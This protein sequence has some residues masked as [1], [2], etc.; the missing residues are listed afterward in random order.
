MIAP[1]LVGLM[2]IVFLLI[3]VW[4]QSADESIPVGDYGKHLLIAFGYYDLI[5]AGHYGAPFREY[6]LYPPLTHLVGA[7]YSLFAGGPT[8]ARMVIAENLVFVPALAFGCYWAGSV[9]FNRLA[10]VLAAVFALGTPMI[11]SLF[12]IFM[13]DGPTAAMVALTVA[14]MLASRRFESLRVSAL[15]GAFAGVGMYT[16]STFVLFIVGLFLTML[17]RGGWRQRRGV[18]TFVG[19]AFVIAGP[20]YIGHFHDLFSQTQGAVSAQQPLW[21]GSHPYPTPTQ[22]LKYTWYGWDLVNQQLYLPLALFFVV[23]TLSL[24]VGWLRDRRPDSLV[25]ELLVGGFVSYATISL[26]TLEDPRYTIPALVYV[27]VLAGGAIAMI[28][29]RRLRWVAVAALSIVA[30]LNTDEINRGSPAWN[31]TINLPGATTNPIGEGTL[32]VFSGVGYF[33]NKP[34]RLPVRPALLNFLAALRHQGAT[35]IAFDATS[36]NNGG[37][38]LD[39]LS[40][41]ARLAD[42]KVA[43]YAADTVTSA[44]TVWIFRNT[45]Q[46]AHHAFC[47]RSPTLNDGT[48]LFAVRGPLGPSARIS[49]PPVTRG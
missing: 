27:A 23:G 21:Y 49:C 26:L 6:N 2:T 36:M 48:G 20:W 29:R 31:L 34:Q 41:L 14:G 42:L 10:G 33:A 24:G 25:P 44:E 40:V 9:A 18:L 46:A 12:H 15:A 43:G 1:A 13:T 30:V 19:V 22:L 16:R 35:S 3:T 4:W 28:E 11:I 7:W 39:T 5:H 32:R 17:I 37:Y 8:I 38:N 45:A 47:I